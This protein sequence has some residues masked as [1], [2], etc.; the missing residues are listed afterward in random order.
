MKQSVH[1]DK[2]GQ[3]SLVSW[4]I[5]PVLKRSVRLPEQGIGPSLS[6]VPTEDK[7]NAEEKHRIYPQWNSTSWSKFS[8]VDYTHNASVSDA[9]LIGTIKQ[10]FIYLTRRPCSFKFCHNT[11]N[12]T[13][14]RRKCVKPL[15]LKENTF[16]VYYDKSSCFIKT[17]GFFLTDD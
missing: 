4:V 2:G 8:T 16:C 13:K 3:E 9:Y 1:V 7:K 11:P 5:N 14:L 12:L 17:V 15:K 10:I 6:P